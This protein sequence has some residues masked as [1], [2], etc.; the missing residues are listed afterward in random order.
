MSDDAA[1]LVAQAKQWASQYGDYSNGEK[2]AAY[3]APLRVRAA[4]EANDPDAFA[5][6]FIE[7]GSMLVGDL[8]LNNREEI[9]SY[10]ADAFGGGYGGSRLTEEPIE[11][12]MLT[13]TVALA[14]TEGG[15]LRAG[16]ETLAPTELVRGT[17]VIVKR[18]GDWRIASRQDCPI[19][20]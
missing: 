7:N 19:K 17:W 3:T 15:V 16:Q 14:I 6:M 11:I 12:R 9:R 13:D 8:Q 18:D 10:M 20:G 2:G 5:E 4:W 1:T